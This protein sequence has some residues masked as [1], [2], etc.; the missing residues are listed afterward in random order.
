M[1]VDDLDTP[2]LLIDLDVVDRNIARLQAYCNDRGLS[3]RPHIKTH[4][5]PALA[6][7]QLAAGARGITCQKLGEAEVMAAAGITDILITFNLVGPQ[8]IERLARLLRQARMRVTA[9]AREILPGLGAA[10]RVANT[11]LPV[12]VEC[13]TGLG[14]NGVQTPP[15][16]GR[17]GP[18][19]IAATDGL[20]FL[21]LMTY[22]TPPAGSE[23]MAEAMAL[24]EQ[25]R[26]PTGGGQRRRHG[27]G[28]PN[29]PVPRGDGDPG[30][31]LPLQRPDH[32]SPRRCHRDRLRATRA[33]HGH[34]PAHP[35]PR[36]PGQRIEVADQRSR[37]RRRPRSPRPRPYRGIPG[38]DDRPPLR[39]A[40]NR[41]PLALR[42]VPA[43]GERVQVIANHCCTVTNLFDLVYAHRGGVIEAIWPVAARGK[44]Q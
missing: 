17:L 19:R 3:L 43:L 10:A 42:E 25:C 22:P 44:V 27:G 30:R 7:R 29:P 11:E 14:R 38:R 41:G 21:G 26:L 16:S 31:K 6:H 39:G 23:W 12:L 33:G 40:W 28:D 36:H 4:K 34:Q 18:G 32:R 24:L 37:A 20:R 8:K 2:A 35:N 9:D 15:R 13:D 1:T 5:I